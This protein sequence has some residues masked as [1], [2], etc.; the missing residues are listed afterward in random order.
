M[1]IQLRN[2]FVFLFVNIFIAALTAIFVGINTKTVFASTSSTELCTTYGSYSTGGNY[3]DGTPSAF[4]VYMTSAVSSGVNRI[5]YNDQCLNWEFVRIGIKVSNISEHRLFTLT[6]DGNVYLNKILAG[7]SNLYLYEG[8]LP[9][10]DYELT[11]V[12]IYRKSVFIMENYTY[13]YRF[14]IDKTAPV[15]TLKSGENTIGSGSFV[16]EQITYSVSDAKPYAIYYKRPGN[17]SYSKTYN[18]YYIVSANEKNN[19]RWFFYS[20]DAY[21]N[22]TAVTEVYLDT[23]APTGIVVSDGKTVG[24]GGFTNKPFKYSATDEGGVSFSQYKLPHTDTWVDY[25]AGTVVSGDYGVYTFRA[26]D[27]AGNVSDEYSI[28]YDKS[29]PS[30]TLYGGLSVKSDGDYTNADYVKY[31]VGDSETGI[32]NCYVKMPGNSYYSGYTSG[33]Q[34]TSQG[35]YY[36]YSVDNAGNVSETVSIT[37][38]SVGP[39]GA[40]YGKSG[41]S[42]DSETTV[43][44]DGNST[45]AEYITYVP[46]D[47]FGVSVSYVILPDGNQSVNYTIGT[48]LFDEGEYSFYSVDKAGNVSEL[49]SVT[50]NRDIPAGQLYVDDEP[51]GNNCYTN[52]AHIKFMCDENCYVKLP[53]SYDFTEYMSGVEYHKPGQYIFFGADDA[54]NFTEMYTITI[55]RT[56]KTVSLTNVYSG[57]TEGDVTIIWEDGDP[58]VYA[59]IREVLI[60]GVK[61]FK[62]EIIYTINTGVYSVSCIDY[63]GNVYNTEFASVKRNVLTTTLKQEYYEAYDAENRYFSF[64]TYDA[65]FNFAV[66]RENSFVT[67][68]EWHNVGWDTGIAM[69]EKDSVNAANGQYYIYKKEGDPKKNVAYF[70]LKRLYEVIYQYAEEDINSYYYWEKLPGVI[71]YNED[72]TCNTDFENYISNRIS[73]TDNIGWK[74]DGVGRAGRDFSDAGKHVLTIYDKWGNVCDYSVNIVGSAPSITYSVNGG[75]VNTVSF[76]RTYYFKDEVT[77][78]IN[79]EIDSMAMFTVYNEYG[80]VMSHNKLDESFTISDNGRYTVR[81]VN[82]YGFSDDF[83]IVISK[84]APKISMVENNSKQ[85]RVYISESA[86]ADSHI[87]MLEVYKSED[88][89]KTWNLLDQDDYGNVVSIGNYEYGFRTSGLYRVLLTDEFRTGI[90]AVTCEFDYVQKE[91]EGTLFGVADGGYASGN[92]S[93]AWKDEAVAVL[94]KDGMVIGY[95]SGDVITENGS[96]VLSF[97]NYDGYKKTYSFVIDNDMPTLYIDG[98]KNGGIVNTDVKVFSGEDRLAIEM[99]VNG[100]SAGEYVSG[101]LLTE[102]G[103]YR[104]IA[105]DD[106]GNVTEVEFTIDKEVSIY[107][108]INDKGIANSVTV[109]L[110]EDAS[111]ILTKDGTETNFVPGRTLS[112]VGHYMLAAI[113]NVGNEYCISF[114]IIGRYFTRF[115]H[116]FDDTP[117]FE[118]VTVNG[119][120]KRLNY[121]TLELFDD[122]TYDVEVYVDGMPYGFTVTVDKT[123]PSLLISGVENGGTATGEVILS[124]LSETAEVTV[125]LNGEVIR[126]ELGDKLSAV[127]SYTVSVKDNSGNVTEYSFNVVKDTNGN[128]TVYVIIAVLLIAGIGVIVFLKKKKVF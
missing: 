71:A 22:Y 84:D 80:K 20:E 49:Y 88:D 68:E 107:V 77:V 27:K 40:V 61:Y 45:N 66:Q 65:A 100:E 108:S 30:G 105:T 124:D 83:E 24:N 13:K 82:H 57:V 6:K 63:A 103:H 67:I 11:Y 102:S 44:S 8:A 58:E 38:D 85:L 73:L 75:A 14:S 81:S 106:A 74:L 2:K 35:T 4:S 56:V 36:F 115:E 28:Y 116:N 21:Y 93:F 101:T 16:N 118:R 104:F 128:V 47:D 7:N 55:D 79:D 121:G 64:A 111:V 96:Y 91:P 3:V 62:D 114:D 60:N 48:K 34:L 86:N 52:G 119:T 89:G 51:I 19:G 54:G 125:C 94:E 97:E 33:M 25:A 50:I 41:L 29:A 126:Y 46:Y 15:Y 69:D 127:G 122:G 120:D 39:K 95:K 32:M 10:G 109:T 78:S 76:N 12:G 59:P 17:S 5:I 112:D 117:G 1:K 92:V 90:D 110:N 43:I 53:D 123:S 98:A 31:V 23:V 26:T 87:Q 70:T 9:D 113:D 42:L 37:L 72:L 18:D 99:F